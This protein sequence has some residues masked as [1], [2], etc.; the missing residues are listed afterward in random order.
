MFLGLVTSALLLNR[1]AVCRQSCV[2]ID[3]NL[4]GIISSALR[5]TSDNGNAHVAR[6]SA[7]ETIS[8]CQSL[9]PTI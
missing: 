3:S 5:Y 8:Q 1:S 4:S 2:V 7:V 9:G 6:L